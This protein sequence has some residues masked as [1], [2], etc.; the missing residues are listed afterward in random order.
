MNE[1]RSAFSNG[2]QY[3]D[4]L[5]SNCLRCKKYDYANPEQS[6]EID[7]AISMAAMSDGQVPLEI[8]DRMGAKSGNY[9]W[10]CPEVDWTDEW[11]KEWE[12]KHKGEAG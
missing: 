3:A 8:F 10:M 5:D 7:N 1:T 6:C 9:I 11:K 12:E 2:T 4:W